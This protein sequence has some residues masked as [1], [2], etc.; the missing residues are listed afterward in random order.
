MF[1][2][3]IREEQHNNGMSSEEVGR[4]EM[5]EETPDVE[6]MEQNEL[7]EEEGGEDEDEG[8]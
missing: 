1:L 5:K 3:R 2:I 7:D 4:E 8:S 6:N